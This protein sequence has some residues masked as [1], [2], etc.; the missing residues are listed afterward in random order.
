[1]KDR[2]KKVRMDH[3]LTQEE[4][5]SSL[6]ISKSSVSLLESGRNSPSKQTVAFLC[7]N[8][9]VSLEWLETGEGDPYIKK[10]DSYSLVEEIRD[11]TKNEHPLMAAVMASL[12]E[13]PPEWWDEW[14]KR[15]HEEVDRVNK[16]KEGT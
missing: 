11:I 1:M 8:F 16:K 13:M 10:D 6:K 2:I 5:A 12:A 7:D 14:S 9:N 3:K 4:F 15:L